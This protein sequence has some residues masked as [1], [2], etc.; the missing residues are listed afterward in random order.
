MSDFF[1]EPPRLG[2][3]FED[4]RVLQS[5]LGATSRR[6]C[7]LRPSRRCEGSALVRRAR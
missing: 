1:Q 3:Q 6:R 7:S 4:D 5:F 2:N